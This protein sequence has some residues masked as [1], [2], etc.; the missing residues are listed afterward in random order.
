MLFSIFIL[1]YTHFFGNFPRS[2]PNAKL[3]YFRKFEDW[4]KSEIINNSLKPGERLPTESDLIKRT[5]FSRQTVRVAVKHLTEEG[6]LTSIQGSGTYVSQ[7]AES[8][9]GPKAS[10]NTAVKIVTMIMMDPNIYIFPEIMNGAMDTLSHHGYTLNTLF[11]G[12]SYDKEQELLTNLLNNPPSGL[13]L[14]PLNMGYLSNNAGLHKKIAS[15]IPTV[16]LHAPKGYPLTNIPTMDYEGASDL[17]DYIIGLGHKKIGTVL[18]MSEST[19]QNAALA[20][21]DLINTGKTDISKYEISP[22]LI[23]RKSV[24]PAR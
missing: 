1:Y 11:T 14:E 23:V 21:L 19:S 9:S 6:L 8:A 13:I 10:G 15:E 2:V 7:K 18:V 5:G 24:A 16:F 17:L 22:K 12:N 3:F 4:I 20:L